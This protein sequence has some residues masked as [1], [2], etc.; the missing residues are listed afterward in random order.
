VRWLVN[1]DISGN[2]PSD[3]EENAGATSKAAYLV[4]GRIRCNSAAARGHNMMFPEQ[5]KF[6]S[7]GAL[8]PT[9]NPS[10]LGDVFA[11]AVRIRTE[12]HD[13]STLR[14]SERPL[15]D[16]R[17]M[18]SRAEI[19]WAL[20][21][22]PQMPS[23]PL[24]DGEILQLIGV[25][26]ALHELCYCCEMLQDVTDITSSGSSPTR[27]YLN[28]VYYYVTSMFLVDRSKPTHKGLPMG[29]TVIVALNPMGLADLLTPI[30]A[31]LNR[32]F[33]AKSTF[34]DAVRKLR[35]SHLVHGDFSP[36]RF[37]FL[38]ADTHMRDP[39]QQERLASNI[40]DLFHQLLLLDLKVNAILTALNP[41]LPAI[42]S[43]YAATH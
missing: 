8:I 33:G 13:Q 40:W 29:G 19:G 6:K 21:K 14:L 1:R 15:R 18:A 36:E 7:I 39:A 23:K 38:V 37:E 31:I 34:G 10:N 26:F 25:E 4:P 17:G 9:A 3:L 16:L 30:D 11:E 28:G 20:F 32:P 24:G 5:D 43:R 27:F 22:N 42:I 41:N 2:A 35:N 12:I